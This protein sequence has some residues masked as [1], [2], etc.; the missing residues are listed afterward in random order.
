MTAPGSYVYYVTQTDPVSGCE[1]ALKGVTL[2]LSSPPVP[3]THDQSVCYGAGVP[4]LIAGGTKI[5]WYLDSL[6]T[7]LVHSGD[8]LATGMTAA[9]TYKYFVTQTDT[10]TSCESPVKVVKLTIYST[11]VPPVSSNVT[12]CFGSTIPD[13]SAT[14]TNIKWYSDGSLTTLVKT[15]NNFTTGKTAVGT[16]TYY[17]TQTTI[18]GVSAA[19]TV[20]LSIHGLPSSPASGNVNACATGTIPGLTASGN[21]IKWY[22]DSLRTHLVATGNNFATGNTAISNYYYYVTQT[23]ASFGCE[24]PVKKVALSLSAPASPVTTDKSIC[25]GAS[26]PDL[27]AIGSNVKWYA[28]SLKTILIHNGDTLSTGMTAAGIYKYYVIQSDINACESFVKG[29]KLTIN[30][31]STVPVLS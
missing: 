6:K 8:T 17:L 31:I 22:S 26:V 20:S 11:A 4:S 16:Y 14:G 25:Y 1:S 9:G 27:V 24:S 19:D 5:K 10:A 30:S 15:G 21:G 13:L 18:C 23:E 29:V 12:A 2:S 7:I 3:T 28:D